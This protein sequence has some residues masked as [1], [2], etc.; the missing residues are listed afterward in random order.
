MKFEIE[1]VDYVPKQGLCLK[2]ESGHIITTQIIDNK[3]MIIQANYQGLLSL[4][5]HLLTLAQAS[6]PA[7]CHFHFDSSNSL[8]A[9]SK[10]L[11][12]EKLP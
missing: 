7:G 8:E 4:A 5:R 9:D 10:E 11:I 2:W 1:V 6:V 3:T 12:I